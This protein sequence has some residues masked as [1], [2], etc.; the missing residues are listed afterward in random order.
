LPTDS[1]RESGG[2]PP[3]YKTSRLIHKA[4]V[5]LPVAVVGSA[6]IGGTEELAAREGLGG[7]SRWSFRAVTSVPQAFVVRAL[8][9]RFLSRAPIDPGPWF[10]NR[11]CAR[12]RR[13][14]AALQNLAVDP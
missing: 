2:A 6:G 9:R 4:F 13:S 11:F 10:A 5:H 3:H 12:K 7:H 1:A 8:L 14:T